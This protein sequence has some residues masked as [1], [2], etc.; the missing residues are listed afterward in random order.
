MLVKTNGHRQILM[1][2]GL[3]ASGTGKARLGAI[4]AVDVHPISGRYAVLGTLAGASSATNQA[5]WGGNTGAGN[6]STQ[7]ILRE[8]T[9]KLRKGQSYSSDQGGGSVRSIAMRPGADV[10]GAGGRG[11]SQVISSGGAVALTLSTDGG[12]SEL[13]LLP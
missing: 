6:D 8:P 5:L 3:P 1:R 11:L 12:V 13:V 7:Q 9:L 4:S 10:T 2:T